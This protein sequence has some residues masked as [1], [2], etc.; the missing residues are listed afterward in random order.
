MII[1]L[2]IH[3]KQDTQIRLSPALLIEAAKLSQHFNDDLTAVHEKA[4][5]KGNKNRATI[6]VAR[7]IVAYLLAVDRREKPFL[8]GE[9]SADAA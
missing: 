5:A 4:L 7:K 8:E 2:S 9:E 6:A 1:P 3:E